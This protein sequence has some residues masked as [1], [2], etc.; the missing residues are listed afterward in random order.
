MT[1]KTGEAINNSLSLYIIKV[2]ELIKLLVNH[3]E[4]TS[5]GEAYIQ[6]NWIIY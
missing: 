6:L 3:K 2:K 1:R 5:C 4:S